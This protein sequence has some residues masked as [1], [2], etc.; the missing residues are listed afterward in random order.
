MNQKNKESIGKIKTVPLREIWKK[1]DKDFSKWLEENIGYLNEILDFDIT[2]ESREEKV[3]PFRV[4]LYGE[5]NFGRKVIIENQLEKTNHDHLGKV[6]TYLTNLEANT[7]IWIT[8][9]PVEAHIKAIEWLNKVTPDD[10][11]FYIIEVKA[12]KIQPGS[13]VAP[14]F[15]IVESPDAE[16]K[17]IG[18]EKKKYAQRHILRKEFWT[19]LLEKANKRSKLH[20][21]I[22]PGMYSWIGAGAG[23]SGI[24]YNYGITNSRG[25]CEIYLDRGKDYEEPN[26]NKIRFDGLFKHKKEIE[27]DFGGK[28]KWQRLDNR[29]ASAITFTFEGVGLK[30]QEKWGKLQDKMVDTM[31]RMNNAFKK[32]I[33]KLK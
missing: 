30:D 5:D 22:S 3:G 28:L 4:D 15:T 17:Q 1:E 16:S 12:I 7:V 2:I 20:A 8:S 21:N 25:S 32:H 24:T 26:I 6:I 19:G 33:S 10:I 18:G 11:S 13:L 9:K 23:K 27:K 29:R 14:L 31:V